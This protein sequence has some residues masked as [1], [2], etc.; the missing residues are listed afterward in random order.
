MAKT[1]YIGEE[2]LKKQK[3]F[4]QVNRD[5]WCEGKRYFLMTYGCQLNENDSERI[6]GIF[7]EMGMEAA[8]S[9][10]E[11]DVVVLNTCAVRENAADRFFGNL[12]I[13]KNLKRD[14]PDLITIACGCL[15]KQSKHVDKIRKSFYFV[16]LVFGPSDIYRIP[17][18][19]NRRLTQ[20]SHVYEVGDLDPIVEDLPIQRKRK[21]RALLSIMFGCNNFCT[22]CIV[23]QSRGRERSRLAES[24]FKE[25]A[26]LEREKYSEVMLLGQNVNSYGKDLRNIE[27]ALSFPQLMDKVAKFDIPRIRFMTSHPR[28]IDDELLYVMRDNPNI[29]RHLHLPIQSGSDRILKLMNRHYTLEEYLTKAKKARQIIP[30]VSITTDIIVGFPGET[31]EDFQATLAAMKEVGYEQSF[32]FIYSP[33]EGTRAAKLEMPDK[34]IVKDR[35]KR[36]SDLQNQ[37]SLEAMKRQE[38]KILELL[39]EGISAQRD[40]RFAGRS[41]ENFLVNFSINKDLLPYD[42]RNL[43]DEQLG[44]LLEGRFA[45][46]KINN[47]KTFSLEGELVELII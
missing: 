44:A 20:D 15:M 5:L 13:I 22:F 1:V 14:K 35:F 29:E 6:A 43:R 19:F 38:G 37:L 47:A 17:E 45:K 41:S 40:D 16:D 11:C 33:R 2:E 42:L 21:Y 32:M 24:I 3:D 7:T 31:E 34:D 30:G 26:D 12:G 39:L 46:V 25:L 36:M 9:V 27:N 28:D 10:E 8:D 18:L 4:I 23:P